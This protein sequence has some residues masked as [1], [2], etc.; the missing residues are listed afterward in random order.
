MVNFVYKVRKI[1][2]FSDLLPDDL[3]DFYVQNLDACTD[4]INH[5]STVGEP[6]HPSLEETALQFYNILLVEKLARENGVVIMIDGGLC[7][8][9]A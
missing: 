3:L 6:N 1:I 7:T 8:A 9:A 2:G 4:A 5:V